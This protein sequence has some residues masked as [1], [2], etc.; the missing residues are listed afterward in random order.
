MLPTAPRRA[1]V[2]AP[3]I[4]TGRVGLV[5]IG[6]SRVFLQADEWTPSGRVVSWAAPWFTVVDARGGAQRMRASKVASRLAFS[7]AG[8]Y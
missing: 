1:R 3:S 2:E 5:R 4:S 6:V 7:P 8:L